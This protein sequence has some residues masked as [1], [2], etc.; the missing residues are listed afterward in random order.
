MLLALV[1]PGLVSV[2]VEDIRTDPAAAKPRGVVAAVSLTGTKV[3]RS[4]S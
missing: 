1:L 4:G 3:C 2:R